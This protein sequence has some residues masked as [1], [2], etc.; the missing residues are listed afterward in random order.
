MGERRASELALRRKVME[1]EAA[2]ELRTARRTVVGRRS[3]IGVDWRRKV[4]GVKFRDV[5]SPA[6]HPRPRWD[7][8]NKKVTS[9]PGVTRRV[10]FYEYLH[11]RAD[12]RGGRAFAWTC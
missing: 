12:G 3:T 5:V 2:G 9:S 11:G 4:G 1:V 8:D 10:I 7:A 6:V